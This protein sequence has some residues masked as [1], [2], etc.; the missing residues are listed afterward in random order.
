MAA[1]N[2][3]SD[4]TAE[5]P[6]GSSLDI[7]G[8]LKIGGVAVTATAAQ[9]NAVPAA[10]GAT[11]ANVAT[12]ADANVIG[13]VPV[14]FRIDVPAGT[15]GNVDVVS[16]HKVRVI[17]VWLVKKDAAGGGAGTIQVKNSTN[18]ITDAMSIDINDQAIARAT[19]INDAY[20]EVAAAGTIR[21]TRTRTASTDEACVVYISALRV[22]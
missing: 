19:T 9:L 17:D 14:V 18:A 15:T 22:A 6:S 21:V 8:T 7:V 4:G 12:V 20:H 13:G 16:T 3:N 10:T 11:G 1:V 2:R 5:V